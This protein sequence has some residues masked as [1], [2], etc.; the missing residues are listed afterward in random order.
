VDSIDSD[1]EYFFTLRIQNTLG[2]YDRS[3][4]VMVSNV[5]SVFTTQRDILYQGN[6]F[7]IGQ[8][9]NFQFETDST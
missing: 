1:T 8:Y 6:F 2:V 9:M 5:Q 7:Q 3:F 4:S